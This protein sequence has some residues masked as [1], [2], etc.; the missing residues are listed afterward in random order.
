MPKKKILVVEDEEPLANIMVNKLEE[1]GFIAETVYNGQE[2]L[3]VLAH[4][5]FDLIIL[6]L[7]L[8]G[9]DGFFILKELK[10]QKNTTPVIVTSNLSQ[11]RDIDKAKKLGIKDYFIKSDA[12]LV[13]LVKHIKKMMK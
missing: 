7:I 3:E 5:K 11:T 2:A 13:D 12:P 9:Q 6:D 4:N 8:P 10:A 1:A